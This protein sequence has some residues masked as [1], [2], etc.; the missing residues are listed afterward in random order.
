MLWFLPPLGAL[1]L[2]AIANTRPIEVL[3]GLLRPSGY[4]GVRKMQDRPILSDGVV[5]NSGSDGSNCRSF[6]MARA[7]TGSRTLWT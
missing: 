1:V 5:L 6:T 4:V 3:L 2:C 7:V